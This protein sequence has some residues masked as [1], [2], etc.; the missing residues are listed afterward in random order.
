MSLSVG[1]LGFPLTTRV[2]G[3]ITWATYRLLEA[4]ARLHP[5][6]T[7]YLVLYE[8]PS[9]GF[10]QSMIAELLGSHPNV[11]ARYKEKGTEAIRYCETHADV[12]WGPASGILRTK[13]VPQVFTHHDMR[14]FGRLRESMSHYIKHRA[15]LN[16]AM[17]QAKVA[18]A[19][20]DST[21]EETLGHY[22]GQKYAKK[23][24]TIPWGVPAGFDDATEVEPQ[25]PDFIEGHRYITTIYDPFP[26]KRMEL[27]GTITPLLDEHGWDLVVMG[28]MRGED[29][30]ILE[31][32][33][34]VHYTGF[35]D[36][37][38]MPRYIKASSLFLFPSEYEGFG[39]PP[40]EAMALGVPVLYNTRCE[41]LARVIG[42]GTH[43]FSADDELPR[44]IGGLMADDDERERHVESA[45]RL[46]TAFDWDLAARGYMYV[47]TE[48]VQRGDQGIDFTTSDPA[49]PMEALGPTR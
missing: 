30:D 32:H 23:T 12:V 27:L 9:E 41:A 40:Y 46:V 36:Y 39:F 24:C 6:H 2:W 31:D 29:I 44:V 16:Y 1:V 49:T 47:F 33:P 48:V 20:S 25:R 19:V 35:V 43:S 7:F 45:N 21:R 5:E 34:R 10:G 4:M 22:K 17:K 11:R 18:V 37:D 38:L 26:H 8:R 42:D 14:M 28:G 15:G 13:R 3:G